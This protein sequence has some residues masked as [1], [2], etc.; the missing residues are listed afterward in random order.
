[1]ND[2]GMT[3]A[4]SA[5]RV[6]LVLVP[7][8]LLHTLASRRSPASGSWIATVGLALSVAIAVATFIPRAGRDDAP[9][10]APMAGGIAGRG[11]EA[12]PARATNVIVG[13][14]ASSISDTSPL[15]LAFSRGLL[16]IWRRLEPAPIVPTARFRRWGSALAVAGIVGIGVGLF[17]LFVGLW[18]IRLCRRRGTIVDDPRLSVLCENIRLALG[19]HRTVEIRELSELTAP[20]TAGWRRPFI[21]LPDDWRSWDNADCRAVLAHEL[22]HI[23]RWDYA[24]GLIARAALV[25]EFYHPLSHWMARRLQFQQELAADAL[26]ARLAG[27]RELYLLSL[28]RLAL[29]QDGRSPS[30]PARAFLPNRGTLI[31]RIATLQDETMRVDRQWSRSRRLGAGLC[32]V[33]SAIGVAMLRGPARGDETEQPGAAPQAPTPTDR[34]SGRPGSTPF[35]MRYVSDE[36]VA[37]IAFRPAATFRHTGTPTFSAISAVAG[38]DLSDIANQLKI[39][40]SAPGRLRL[41][42]DD[43]EWVIVG[44]D[45]GRSIVLG[46]DGKPLPRGGTDAKGEIRHAFQFGRVTLRTTGR[47]DWLKFLREWRFDFIEVPREGR[48]YFKIAGIMTTLLGSNPTSHPCVYL[49]DDR[50]IVFDDEAAIRKMLGRPNPVVPTYL[51]GEDWERCSRGVLAVA[52]NNQDGKFAKSYDLGQ[53]DDAIILS[54]FKGVDRWILGVVDDDAAVLHATA[55]CH[56]GGSVEPVVRSV[57]SLVTMARNALEHPATGATPGESDQRFLRIAKPLV[58]NVRVGRNGHSVEIGSDGFGRFAEFGSL[59]VEVFFE[60]KEHGG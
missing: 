20:A 41:A 24:A 46:A 19:C 58:G 34:D 57:E 5:V 3:L 18:A 2:L 23:H 31:R 39:D 10:A 21:M 22:A 56:D 9:V 42:P 40:L 44:L 38:L 47:F 55:A 53:P 36:T 50:T 14:R 51:A 11:A 28:S 25:F 30:W 32:L 7:A 29:K 4:W 33:A 48:P 26:G 16:G 12:S 60:G 35:D 45:F 49:P 13:G 1:M 37:V 59:A 54:L 43:I 52:I 17:R 27:G 8:A 6:T 15:E